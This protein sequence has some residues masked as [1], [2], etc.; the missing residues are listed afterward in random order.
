MNV[1]FYHITR[2]DTRSSTMPDLMVRSVRRHMPDA[3]IVQFGTDLSMR[4]TDVNYFV[5]RA[6]LP[7][8]LALIEYK[9][10]ISVTGEDWLFL[11]TDVV[12]QR[13]VSEV[14]DDREFDLAVATR[15]GTMRPHEV[16]SRFM[17]RNPYNCGAIFSRSAEFWRHAYARAEQH[18]GRHDWGCDQEA[19]CQ[20]IA[21]ERYRVKVLPN[22]YNYPP[23][24]ADEDVSAKAIVHYK[25]SRKKW[26]RA[27]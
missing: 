12:V 19:M 21:S 1:G 6:P 9:K 17:A 23:H 26:M 3:W 25:G 4:L 20:V 7:M 22:D 13:N 27:A 14:F 2:E 15:E 11:D 5:R 10:F 8:A 16:G 18:I 24:S